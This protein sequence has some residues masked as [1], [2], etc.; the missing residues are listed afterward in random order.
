MFCLTLISHICTICKNR[1]FLSY[2]C[3]QYSVLNRLVMKYIKLR[4]Y[5]TGLLMMTALLYTD[6]I[7]GQDVAVLPT[8]P[9]VKSGVLPNGMKWY[10]ATNPYVK[11][12]ADFALVQM[13]GSETIPSVGRETVVEIAQEALMKQ[14][15]LTATSVQEYFISKG[16]VPGPEGFAEVREN[17]TIFRFRDVNLKLSGSVLDS[18]LLVMMNI[19]GRYDRSFD[20]VLKKWYTPS[21]QAIIVAGD[22]DANTVSEKL[23]MLSYMMPVAETVARQGYVWESVPEVRTDVCHEGEPGIARIAAIWKLERTP[24]ELMN[25]V[26]PA[27]F[28]KYMTMTGMVARERIL[29][30]FKDM[31]IPVASVD[32]GYVGGLG[33][34]GDGE[35]SVEISIAQENSVEAASV[36]AEV[37]SA[38]DFYGVEPTEAGKASLDFVDMISSEVRRRDIANVEYVNRCVSAFVYNTSLSSRE[39]IRKFYLS[40]DISADTE[41][42]LL[43]SIASNSL[44]GNSNLTLRYSADSLYVPMKTL[45]SAFQDSWQ[46]AQQA[47]PEVSNTVN[48]PYFATPETEAKVKSVKSEYLSGGS[49]WTLTNGMRIIIKN[50]ETEGNVLHYSLSLN[51]GSGNVEG[52]ALDEGKCLADYLEHCRFGGISGKEFKTAIRRRGVKM[53]FE[54]GPASTVI[55]GE[56]PAYELEY[57]FRVLISLMNDRKPDAEAWDYYCKC[58]ALRHKEDHLSGISCLSAGFAGHAEAFFNTLS[59]NVNNG[60]L[61]FVGNVDEKKLKVMLTKYAGEFKTTDK[62]F[63]RT[64]MQT[65]S[66]AGIEKHERRGRENSVS[67]LLT[68]PMALTAENYYTAA[69]TSMVLRRHFAQILAGKGMRV[70][71]DYEC[72]RFPQESLLMRVTVSE[73]SADGFASGTLGYSTESALSVMRTVFENLTDINVDKAVLASY[74]ERL[75]KRVAVAKESPEYWVDAINYRYLDGKDFATGAE[76]KIKGIA[77]SNVKSL[78][79]SLRSNSKMK[80][81]ITT[82]K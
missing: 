76:G 45:L 32:V 27:V 59:Q 60:V 22:V 24:R 40:K 25:T 73:A 13:T 18:T 71:V 4:Q 14:P 3:N 37:L 28:R 31:G 49:M 55:K 46:K 77:E 67:M 69:V 36:L 48:V 56:V 8:D 9:A 72:R 62:S 53:A 30:K 5:I 64:E 34:I 54:V 33:T 81:I 74:K 43:F 65:Q 50:M 63:R 12:A 78:L 16:C 51:G 68:A 57:L 66:F 61:V 75:E 7:Y 19:A 15:L 10:V 44:D 6:A 1:N 17:A 80:Y 52:V 58:A 70:N 42:R 21:D 38:M 23:K 11:G 41:S 82:E 29:E 39:G 20:H 2:F 35:F 26:Q 47:K 79:A